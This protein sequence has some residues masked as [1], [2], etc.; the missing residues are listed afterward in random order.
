[1]V[2]C[3]FRDPPTGPQ[4]VH[5]DKLQHQGDATYLAALQVL[6]TS[7]ASVALGGL[8]NGQRVIC[9]EI[10]QHKLALPA[11]HKTAQAQ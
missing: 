11:I 1:M 8:K 9:Q 7:D 2:F 6:A 4:N 10:R 5:S 3:F